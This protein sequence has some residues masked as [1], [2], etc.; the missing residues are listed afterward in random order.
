MYNKHLD[1]FLMVSK[2]GS[3]SSAAEA[4]YIT[5]SAVIQQIN[6]LEAELGAVL[7]NRTRKGVTLTE[8]GEY[9]FTAGS[10][11]VEKGKYIKHQLAFLNAGKKTITIGTSQDFKVRLLFDLWV[12]FSEVN[13]KYDL[14]MMLIDHDIRNI[15]DAD[16]V[17]GFK[18]GTLWDSE[19]DFFKICDMPLGCAVDKH[20]PLY[21]KKIL[22][23]D[24]LK[25]RTLITNIFAVKE[26]KDE[27]YK[28]L[29][30][31]GILCKTT[32]AFSPNIFLETAMKHYVL[33]IPIC[34]QDVM[35]D[36]KIIPVEWK[37]SVDYGLFYRKKH[38]PA[39][40]ELIRFIRGI[41]NGTIDCG[42]V[43]VF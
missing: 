28:D 37:Y 25:N 40:E 7:F 8:A 3:F 41:Y 5:P 27:L 38:S 4:L 21:Y 12:L 20:D 36:L 17:E 19:M 24:D 15:P 22:T 31:H 29:E 14:H 26:K 6:S 10:D 2:T 11:Y 13:K 23:Y 9:L 42:V 32:E 16:L 34:M 30:S 33:Q 35:P 1:T 39:V 43:P 18:A